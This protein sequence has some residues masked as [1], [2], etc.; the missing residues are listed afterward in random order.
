MQQAVLYQWQIGFT[1]ICW[2]FFWH[3]LFI[4]LSF[5]KFSNSFINFIIFVKTPLNMFGIGHSSENHRKNR[6]IPLT[7]E[8]FNELILFWGT[9]TYYAIKIL[10]VWLL[11]TRGWVNS[12]WNDMPRK[13]FG[14]KQSRYSI[15][16][17][18][19]K[20]W[21][22][23]FSILGRPIL[24][25]KNCGTFYLSHWITEVWCRRDHRQPQ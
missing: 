5:K 8:N 20:Y 12:H 23:T 17:S 2:V 11:S 22:T 10:W 16:K 14:Y 9:L 15:T 13:P 25:E 19:P 6:Q 4:I 21:A 24:R 7:E 1:V 3:L 18:G